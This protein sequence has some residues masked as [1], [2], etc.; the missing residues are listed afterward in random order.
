MLSLMPAL[1][2]SVER[3]IITLFRLLDHLFQADIAA[4]LIPGLVEQKKRQ[5]PGHTAISIEKRMDAEEIK[6]IGGNEKKRFD[7]SSLPEFSE[8]FVKRVHG[9]WSHMSRNRIKT[10][11]LCT[12]GLDFYNLIVR[13]FPLASLAGNELIKVSMELQDDA[14]GER[15]VGIVSVNRIKDIPVTGDFLL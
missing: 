12:I 3:V 14:G 5:E 11:N 8:L 2:R 1:R 9:I 4:H 6:N 13:G 15:N 7:L 10:D